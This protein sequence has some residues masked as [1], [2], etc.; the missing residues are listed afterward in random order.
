MLWKIT[1]LGALSLERTGHPI[2]T[3][4]RSRKAAG[5][6]AYL[7]LYHGQHAREMLIG[8]F[9]PEDETAQGQLNLRV[10]LNSLRKQ[11]EPP[12][13]KPQSVLISTRTHIGLSAEAYTTDVSA[14]RQ[15]I[16]NGDVATIESF[17]SLELLSGFY[18]DWSVT[19]AERLIVLLSQ[20]PN[21]RTL[22]PKIVSETP[23]AVE[24][25]P[26]KGERIGMPAHLD[27]FFGREVEH[28]SLQKIFASGVKNITVQGAGGSGK[29]RLAAMFAAQWEGDCVFVSLADTTDAERLLD[30]IAK[31]CLTTPPTS[32]TLDNLAAYWNARSN[33]LLVLDNLEQL[34]GITLVRVLGQLRQ[35]LPDLRLLLTSRQRV[36]IAGERLFPLATLPLPQV[37]APLEQLATVP[38]MALFVDRAQAYRGDFQL[39]LRNASTLAQLIQTL[40][41]V[42]LAIELAASWIGLFT[43]AQILEQVQASV[44]S[45]KSR[46]ERSETKGRH[47]SLWAVAAWSYNLLT[48]EL[49][50]LFS[51]LALF[52]G[53]ADVAAIQT[54]C[55]NPQPEDALVRLMERSLLR[56][57]IETGRFSLP[58]ALREFALQQMPKENLQE[59]EW[60]HATYFGEIAERISVLFTEKKQVILDQCDAEYG[61]FNRAFEHAISLDTPAGAQTALQ[62]GAYLYPLWE[63]RGA[64][65]ESKHLLTQALEQTYLVSLPVNADTAVLFART[66]AGLGLIGLRERTLHQSLEHFQEQLR[67]GNE[68]SLFQQI[69]LA[70][71]NIGNALSYQGNHTAAEPYFLESITMIRNHQLHGLANTLLGL[72][73]LYTNLG[74]FDKAQQYIDEV[75]IEQRTQGDWFHLSHTLI[76][77][78]HLQNK[79]GNDEG[80]IES[81]REALEIC[82]STNNILNAA[83][84]IANMSG[85]YY[86]KKAPDLEYVTFLMSMSITLREQHGMVIR[87]DEKA[88]WAV[89][90]KNIKEII[91]EEHF[92]R[93]IIRG[94]NADW[95]EVF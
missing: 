95:K 52:R 75:K 38:S 28:E 30:E 10:T 20:I 46:R 51:G 29:T 53:G 19:E 3:R 4:F 80:V 77:Q 67:I 1:L 23:V 85:A 27:R 11:L 37:N 57:D 84:A 34:S 15:A 64:L 45:L 87:D 69:A 12:G 33:P 8:L 76:Y 65:H 13:V 54:V 14:L 92:Q 91:G 79:Q 21:S 62:L 71:S 18:D 6:L 41:G 82:K 55:Q 22:L 89:E 36:R 25:L 26:Q 78:S 17:P 94:Q 44:I 49:Q 93:A 61:N 63:S 42:P 88:W 66:Y 68:F 83:T 7:A 48:P 81:S 5:L 74:Q 59:Q 70:L 73:A 50:S 39:T 2:I 35:K 9:W 31:T 72:V 60:R 32:N 47:E 16:K 40:E 58:E 86:D 90:Q 43:P 24:Q 56:V